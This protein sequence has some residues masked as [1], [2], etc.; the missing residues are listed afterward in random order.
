ML[1]ILLYHLFLGNVKYVCIVMRRSVPV[2]YSSSSPEPSTNFPLTSCHNL[3]LLWL[4]YQVLMA[5]SKKA[6]KAKAP[7]KT[8]A[9][10]TEFL[11]NKAE[12]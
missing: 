2:A 12:N 7:V 9:T 11:F 8:V 3:P 10:K 4:S 5:E 6:W 1:S